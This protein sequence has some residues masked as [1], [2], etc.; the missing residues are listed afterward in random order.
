MAAD[1][2]V[3]V[4]NHPVSLSHKYP[5]FYYLTVMSLQD[6]TSTNTS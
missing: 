2:P 4:D 1:T 3:K 6:L 5:P